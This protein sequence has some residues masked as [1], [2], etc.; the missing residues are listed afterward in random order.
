MKNTTDLTSKELESKVLEALFPENLD[1]LREKDPTWP[2]KIKQLLSVALSTDADHADKLTGITK[3]SYQIL[4]L[5]GQTKAIAYIQLPMLLEIQ[6]RHEKVIEYQLA[7]NFDTAH[8]AFMEHQEKIISGVIDE[9]AKQHEGWSYEDFCEDFV[10]RQ[11]AAEK[12]LIRLYQKF[13]PDARIIASKFSEIAMR[14]ADKIEASDKERY[15]RFGVPYPGQSELV[16]AFRNCARMALQ[17]VEP[18]SHNASPRVV[19]P[20]LPI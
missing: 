7:H 12:L 6:R 5:T 19:M 15:E 3:T 9:T 2:E 8:K 13:L 17:R 11:R 18:D 10:E 20:Y 1:L 14:E 4:A 16:K